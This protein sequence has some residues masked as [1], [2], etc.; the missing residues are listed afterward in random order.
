LSGSCVMR[1]TGSCQTAPEKVRPQRCNAA[2]E[3]LP[4]GRR[5]DGP[6]L[7]A[8]D[9][10]A[11]FVTYH[12]NHPSVFECVRGYLR[13]VPVTIYSDRLPSPPPSNSTATSNGAAPVTVIRDHSGPLCTFV[14]GTS[15][16]N[17]S[18]DCNNRWYGGNRGEPR[19]L[20]GVMHANLTN[21]RWKWL[22]VGDDDTTWNVP[23]VLNELS[24]FDWRK[25]V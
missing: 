11:M 16:L 23:R 21:K 25:P 4:I 5:E 6:A 15:H 7:A 3:P 2:T 17:F 18:L 13:N 8:D 24:R 9:L 20:G 19:F 22:L 14:K 10:L 12:R 1:Q